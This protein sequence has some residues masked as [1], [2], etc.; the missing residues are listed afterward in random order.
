MENKVVNTKINTFERLFRSLRNKQD[1]KNEFE[2]KF[3]KDVRKILKEI[4][5]N[6]AHDWQANTLQK[7]GIMGQYL[8]L[9]GPIG[10]TGTFLMAKYFHEDLSRVFPAW[11]LRDALALEPQTH[12]YPPKTLLEKYNISAA[13]CVGE[14]GLRRTL[15]QLGKDTNSG[16]EVQARNVPV[17]QITIEFCEYYDLDP[18]MLFSSGCTLLICSRPMGLIQELKERKIQSE[19]IGIMTDNNDKVI[20]Y[21]D[22][23]SLVNRPKADA[24]LTK[25]LNLD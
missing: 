19:V 24:L 4:E 11:L 15:Y 2:E 8:V 22:T 13:Y 6:Q 23:R 9:A 3:C 5:L 17:N 21:G 14:G 1:G 7:A 10:L 25:W 18:W 16:F 20:T 12:L